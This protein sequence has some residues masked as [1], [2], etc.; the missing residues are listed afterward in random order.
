MDGII[1]FY[2]QAIV[3][4]QKRFS[5]FLWYAALTALTTL[6][7]FLPG[8]FRILGVVL[9]FLQLSYPFIVPILLRQP[10]SRAG[11]IQGLLVKTSHQLALPFIGVG[12]IIG[13][14]VIVFFVVIYNSPYE[15]FLKDDAMIAETVRWVTLPGILISLLFSFTPIVYAEEKRSLFDSFARSFSIVLRHIPILVP[16][17][18][19]YLLLWGG[20][21]TVFRSLLSSQGSFTLLYNVAASYG[22]FVVLVALY[23]YY[24][25]RIA[26]E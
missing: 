21:M 1:G 23:L 18:V 10:Q 9:V 14:F 11:D 16:S 20:N 2:R 6:V 13:F 15:S 19:Y 7:D 3:L 5:L 22:H 17:I 4:V 24:R 8:F 12:A 26:Q 25:K